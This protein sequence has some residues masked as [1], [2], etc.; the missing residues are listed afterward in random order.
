MA[1]SGMFSSLHE[2]HTRNST[3]IKRPPNSLLV[4][5]RWV[6]CC[7]PSDLP[8]LMEWFSS[9]GHARIDPWYFC[10]IP[11]FCTD[12]SLLA[13]QLF[14]TFFEYTLHR[15]Y[16]EALQW[17]SLIAC[18]R[19]ATTGRTVTQVT[20]KMQG[21]R[22]MRAL[23]G[24]SRFLQIVPNPSDTHLPSNAQTLDKWKLE[25]RHLRRGIPTS[26]MELPPALQ[27]PSP[28]QRRMAAVLWRLRWFPIHFRYLRG[29]GLGRLLDRLQLLREQKASKDIIKHRDCHWRNKGSEATECLTT[30]AVTN[31]GYNDRQQQYSF[32]WH[33]E[34]DKNY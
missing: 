4:S 31:T 11:H 9:C 27:L 13:L 21:K 7:L 29:I 16:L 18:V 3:S 28:V 32:Q 20:Q 1:K 14:E 10:R 15:H 24:L 33:W 8:W 5:K 26:S 17:H 30:V 19:S 34:S 23:H 2:R 22:T 6:S 25:T 12:K